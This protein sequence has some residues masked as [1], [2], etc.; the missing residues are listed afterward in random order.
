VILQYRGETRLLHINE[1][2][3]KNPQNNLYTGGIPG[4]EAMVVRWAA[5]EASTLPQLW[6]RLLHGEL[7]DVCCKIP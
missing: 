2:P 7:E 4:E 1:I 3:S 6:G 5:A